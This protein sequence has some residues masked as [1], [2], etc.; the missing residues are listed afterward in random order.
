ME[1]PKIY[2]F[3]LA[4]GGG[5]GMVHGSTPGG[6]V[7]GYAFTK[8]GEHLAGH[9]SSSIGFSKHDL[10]LTS[11]WNHEKY[12]K[13]YPD[14]YD[15]EWVDNPKEYEATKTLFTEKITQ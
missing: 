7:I 2:L 5:S 13:K 12:K 1:K 8:D 3:C 6:D 15:L 11:D 9:F 4:T 14:G 10:G